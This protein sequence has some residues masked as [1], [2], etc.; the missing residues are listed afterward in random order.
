MRKLFLSIR[1][2]CTSFALLSSCNYLQN[3]LNKNSPTPL[4][5]LCTQVQSVW[6]LPLTLCREISS[7]TH[8]ST[9]WMQTKYTN[10]L[11]MWTESL[12]SL[13]FAQLKLNCVVQSEADFT[14]LWKMDLWGLSGTS[15]GEYCYGSQAAMV[16]P[17]FQT[18][19][20]QAPLWSASQFIHTVLSKQRDDWASSRM[21]V[22]NNLCG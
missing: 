16:F 8:F 5:W 21:N 6:W 9:K 7:C 10:R 15:W 20:R 17:R 14:L 18:V 1:R 19:C 22:L 4:L 12:W 11:E 2:G 13:S 3:E